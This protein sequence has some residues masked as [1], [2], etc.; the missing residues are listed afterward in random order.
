MRYRSPAGAQGHGPE[1]RTTELASGGAAVVTANASY[2][3]RLQGWKKPFLPG[4]DS[5]CLCSNQNA[6]AWQAA[7][8]FSLLR[9]KNGSSERGNPKIGSSHLIRKISHQPG[10]VHVCTARLQCFLKK[11]RKKKKVLLF[12]VWFIC[13]EDPPPKALKRD[14]TLCVWDLL[15]ITLYYL[16]EKSAGNFFCKTVFNFILRAAA[17]A[18]NKVTSTR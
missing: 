14:S 16:R 13:S 3:E 7:S 15:K 17:S 18:I 4:L 5:R 6:M 10:G 12:C 1:P 2:G 8:T 11:K 9:N